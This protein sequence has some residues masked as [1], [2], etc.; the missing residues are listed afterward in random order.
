MLERKNPAKNHRTFFDT[1]LVCGGSEGQMPLKEKIRGK[2]SLRKLLTSKHLG[3]LEICRALCSKK[4]GLALDQNIL[5][6]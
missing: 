2:E 3:K 5:T 6:L 4:V 1:R